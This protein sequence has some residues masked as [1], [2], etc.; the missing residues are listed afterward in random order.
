LQ[1]FFQSLSGKVRSLT[2]ADGI[3]MRAACLSALSILALPAFADTPLERALAA[4]SDG[5]AYKF[6][7]SIDG[8]TLKGT[9]EVDPTRPE[10]ERLTLLS[11]SE[12]ELSDAGEDQGRQDLVQRL[13]RQH[14]SRCKADFR[15]RRGRRLQL[16][17]AAR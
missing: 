9:A 11:P 16:P 6:E 14:S 2:P 17:S 7:L 8:D 3:L 10:G 1:V 15:I 12:E 13:C 5:P 4:P